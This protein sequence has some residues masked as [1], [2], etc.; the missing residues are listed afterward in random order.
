MAGDV[1]VNHGGCS[2]PS[3][4]TGLTR[5]A[6]LAAQARSSDPVRPEPEE[7]CDTPRSQPHSA[8]IH[9]SEADI[10]HSPVPKRQRRE[11]PDDTIVSNLEVVASHIDTVATILDAWEDPE[12]TELFDQAVELNINPDIVES[13]TTIKESTDSVMDDITA[14]LN[15]MD[16]PP[17][18]D[19]MRAA[20]VV[21]L[22]LTS[23]VVWDSR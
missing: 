2:A 14:L 12:F 17:S 13:R 10:L 1:I 6:E 3:T 23:P 9:D 22:Q 7:S 8:S 20:K 21:A 16:P 19:F 4:G 5:E 18:E 15:A 11:D